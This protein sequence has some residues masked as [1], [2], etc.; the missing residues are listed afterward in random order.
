[1]FIRVFAK[2]RS[3]QGQLDIT[4]PLNQGFRPRFVNGSG[5]FHSESDRRLGSIIRK[6]LAHEETLEV[7]EE[8]SLIEILK[9]IASGALQPPDELAAGS[10]DFHVTEALITQARDAIAAAE[11]P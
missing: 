5:Q 7:A 11:T 3:P 6:G 1:M 4:I 2:D 9:L 8:L 10:T